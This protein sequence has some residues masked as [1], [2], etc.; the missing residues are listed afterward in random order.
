MDVTMLKRF[1]TFCLITLC[2]SCSLLSNPEK[3]H[4]AAM[5]GCEKVNALI[6]A[7]GNGFEHLK[8]AQSTTKRVNVWKARYHLV[9]DSCQIW[10]W[11][12]RSDYVCSKIAPTEDIARQWYEKAK[13]ETRQCL[14]DQWQLQESP[15]KV[16]TGT[17][18]VFSKAGSNTVVTVH[19]VET[20]GV[21]K[22]EWAAYYF[23]GDLNQDL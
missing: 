4:V 7:H 8:M 10:G 3:E 20:R 17:K 5:S 6:A 9:G 23:V 14:S 1:A 15:R 21:F 22:S 16:G 13:T 12:N 2:S 11:G 19:A 18:A